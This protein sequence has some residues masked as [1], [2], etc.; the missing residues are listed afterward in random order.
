MAGLE[1]AGPERVH[2]L[3]GQRGEEV[4]CALSAAYAQHHTSHEVV[5]DEH[6]GRPEQERVSLLG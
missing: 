5:R 3:T 4:F 2:G 1:H 6:V